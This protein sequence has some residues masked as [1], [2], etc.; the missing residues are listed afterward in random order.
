MDNCEQMTKTFSK[1]IRQQNEKIR[2]YSKHLESIIMLPKM[3]VIMKCC[4]NS[5]ESMF[6][7][8]ILHSKSNTT[9]SEKSYFPSS[10][11]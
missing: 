11:P 2:S 8:H 6:H 4:S 9:I 3:S 10:L 7:L 1:T 5:D